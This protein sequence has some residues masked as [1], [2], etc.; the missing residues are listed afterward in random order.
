MKALATKPANLSMIPETTWWEEK[1][2]S[3][4]LLALWHVLVLRH[5]LA[6][7]ITPSTHLHS[8]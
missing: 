8:R 7:H 1:A 6:Q 2:V 4:S 5:T 3:Q